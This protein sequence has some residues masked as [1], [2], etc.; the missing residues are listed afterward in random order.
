LWN[1]NWK[2]RPAALLRGISRDIAGSRF[3][4][5]LPTE[6]MHQS[7]SAETR[8]ERGWRAGIAQR[9][10]HRSLRFCS[11]RHNCLDSKVSGVSKPGAQ[12]DLN[13]AMGLNVN[14]RAGHWV[15]PSTLDPHHHRV[16]FTL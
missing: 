1:L 8:K 14:L 2:Y 11:I 3:Q 9:W 10:S 6:I 12:S 15:A 16:N 4:A 13:R 7:R 5:E